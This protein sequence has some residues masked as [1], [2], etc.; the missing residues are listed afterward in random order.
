M[1]TSRIPLASLL[2]DVESFAPD[3]S[4]WMRFMLPWSELSECLLVEDYDGD[5]DESIDGFDY[6]LGVD[7]VQDV[8]ANARLQKEQVSIHE[9]VSALSFYCKNDAFINLQR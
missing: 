8:V 4:L 9:L 7:A 5:F 3:G 6:C 2:N 1:K